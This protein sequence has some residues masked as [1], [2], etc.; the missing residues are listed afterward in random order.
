MYLNPSG[1]ILCWSNIPPHKGI[2][3][4]SLFILSDIFRSACIHLKTNRMTK[5][6][7]FKTL[8]SVQTQNPARAS[9]S[10]SLLC[11]LCL[12][13]FLFSPSFSKG[14]NC[15]WTVSCI[16]P[17][18]AYDINTVL[19]WSHRL[20]QMAFSE[21]QR[22]NITHL[23]WKQDQ[24]GVA[25]EHQHSRPACAVLSIFI[26]SAQHTFDLCNLCI[27]FDFSFMIYILYSECFNSGQLQ[28]WMWMK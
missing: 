5:Q 22:W 1:I 21:A 7:P 2:S 4:C 28:Q 3:V 16:I 13:F 6:I 14:G 17:L 12:H 23:I 20:W 9:F 19:L 25:Q 15:S 11:S 26:L 27:C 10:P 8:S 24:E 18:T